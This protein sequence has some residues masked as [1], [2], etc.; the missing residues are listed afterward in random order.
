MS[1]Q[2]HAYFI[3][4][5][6]LKSEIKHLPTPKLHH[7]AFVRRVGRLVRDVVTEVRY[8]RGDVSS[9]P[10]AAIDQVDFVETAD[11]QHAPRPN[12]RPEGARDT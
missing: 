2:I 6:T 12:H 8:R 11:F 3:D 7:K 1:Y 4:S 5:M 10:D 9:T